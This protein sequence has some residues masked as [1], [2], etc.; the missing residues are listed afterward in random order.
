MRY[1]TLT[2]LVLIVIKCLQVFWANPLYQNEEEKKKSR[3]SPSSGT[4]NLYDTN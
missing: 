3:L 2:Y 4:E 1:H